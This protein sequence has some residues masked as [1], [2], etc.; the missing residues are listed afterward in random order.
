MHRLLVTSTMLAGLVA[1]PVV[2]PQAAFA[3]QEPTSKNASNID[4][5]DSHSVIA[6]QL[7]APPAGDE[8]NAQALLQA[9][10]QA[11]AANETG[12]AQESLERA[13]TRLLTRSTPADQAGAPDSSGAV[14]L[15]ASARMAIAHG[16]LNG[17]NGDIQQALGQLPQR[18]ASTGTP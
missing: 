14:Q 16:D 1:L 13:E 7:P 11:L 5:A 18:Q 12:M 4:Q 17:A 10:S 8:A 6:P 3:G 9:A 15:I 2:T